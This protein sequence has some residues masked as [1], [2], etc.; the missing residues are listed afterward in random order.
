MALII[1]TGV[2]FALRP[3]FLDQRQPVGALEL[4]V[5]H[6]NGGAAGERGVHRLR[7]GFAH[8][9][10]VTTGQFLRDRLRE[11]LLVFADID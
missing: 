9:D 1:S 3:Q 7:A 8:E 10:L 11:L 6:Q 4:A 2:R 5:H